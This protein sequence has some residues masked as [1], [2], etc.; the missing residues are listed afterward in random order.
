VRRRRRMV[1]GMSR[2]R[3]RC[4]F[5]RGMGVV[6]GLL[7][8]RGPLRCGGYPFAGSGLGLR[9][10][11]TVF[12]EPPVDL[13][14]TASWVS[15]VAEKTFAH[16]NTAVTGTCL[17]RIGDLSLCSL[18]LIFDGDMF[19]A[20]RARIYVAKHGEVKGNNIVAW[21]VPNATTA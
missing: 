19:E 6:S 1:G 7:G 14:D 18:S 15:E 10:W 11:G 5:G 13:N 12:V 8:S 3:S 2:R 20:H 4:G 16:V 9:G 21:V 17:T